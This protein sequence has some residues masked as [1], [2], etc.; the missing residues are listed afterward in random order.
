MTEQG[1]GRTA[2]V[3]GASAGIG[4][5]FAE[6]LASRGWDLALTAR[7]E[8]RL[9][10][11]Q[12]GLSGRYGVRVTVVPA[13][14]A[15][16]GAS[17][18]IVT[19]LREVP[20][21]MLV[22]NAGYTLY[23]RYVDF[24]WE[25]QRAMLQVMGVAVCELTHRLLGP[26]VERGFGRIVNVASAGGFFPGSPQYTLYAPVKALGIALAEGID[27]EYRE[28]GIH[29]T[30]SAPGFTETEI[31]DSSAALREAADSRFGRLTMQS[32]DTV[33]REAYDAVMAGRRLV[34]HGWWAK[35][36]SQLLRRGPRSL[37]YRFVASAY[38]E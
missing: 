31:L 15:D 7:R 26:M 18:Q 29:A 23:G 19:S 4:R 25:E 10:E 14:L 37:G 33:A 3:T 30:A 5:A 32:A 12:A 17:E 6:L 27:A 28:R 36:L 20:I 16:P 21:D 34:V 13:D 2:L 9:R 22:N 35:T 8:Q 1:R 11:L 38:T 24:S